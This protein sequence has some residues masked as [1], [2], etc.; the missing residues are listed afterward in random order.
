MCLGPKS[1]LR[2]E[3]VKDE[4]KILAIPCSKRDFHAPMSLINI[5]MKRCERSDHETN[6]DKGPHY[7]LNSWQ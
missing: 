6:L 3:E 2:S 4:V 5:F 7:S 1:D